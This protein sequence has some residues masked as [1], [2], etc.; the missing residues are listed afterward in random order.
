MQFLGA[1]EQEQRAFLKNPNEVEAGEPGQVNDI[2]FPESAPG[3]VPDIEFKRP[4]P[5]FEALSEQIA[6][7]TEAD[8]A[9]E[10]I[11]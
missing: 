2:L 9:P 7:L 11:T 8:R 5:E 6:S 10:I 1:L 4:A 3:E